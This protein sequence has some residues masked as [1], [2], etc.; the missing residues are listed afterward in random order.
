MIQMH[1]KFGP[2]AVIVAH[3]SYRNGTWYRRRLNLADVREAQNV[4]SLFGKGETEVIAYP[5]HAPAYIAE[6]G[7]HGLGIDV[8]HQQAGV[9]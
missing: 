6:Q 3:S 9:R 4:R 2:A 8:T 1:A 5:L 7:P